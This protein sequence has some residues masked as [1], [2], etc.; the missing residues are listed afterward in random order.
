MDIIG[1]VFLAAL[2]FF[3]IQ[4]LIEVF[5]GS[6]GLFGKLIYKTTIGILFIVAPLFLLSWL[7]FIFWSILSDWGFF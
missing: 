2:G 3:L 1:I 4:L 5:E 7:G 6:E